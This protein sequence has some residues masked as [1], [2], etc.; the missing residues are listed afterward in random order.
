MSLQIKIEGAEEGDLRSGDEFRFVSS[1]TAMASSTFTAITP[2][3]AIVTRRFSNLETLPPETPVIAH[4][5]GEWRTDAFPSTVGELRA[6]AEAWAQDK[7]LGKARTLLQ[8]GA[9][10]K[11]AAKK[12]RLDV[13]VVRKLAKELRTAAGGWP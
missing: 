3:G 8:S 5:H 2:S 1:P 12:T 9:S 6:K 10:I 13:G 11:D 7:L 4:W